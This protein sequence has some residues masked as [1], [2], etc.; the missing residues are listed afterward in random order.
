M[1]LFFLPFISRKCNSATVR[2]RRLVGPAPAQGPCTFWGEGGLHYPLLPH[3]AKVLLG[4]LLQQ[5]ARGLLLRGGQGLTVMTTIL[6][7]LSLRDGETPALVFLQ[8]VFGQPGAERER[9]SK[10]VWAAAKPRRR[11]RTA[12]GAAGGGLG[13]LTEGAVQLPDCT[14][15][16]AGPLP[17]RRRRQR[18]AAR[19]LRSL[20]PRSRAGS[21][22]RFRPPLARW[23]PRPQED[24]PFPAP[25]G[26]GGYALASLYAGSFGGNVHSSLLF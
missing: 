2:A 16:N 19:P 6:P 13:E 1:G 8:H 11:G 24:P 4:P 12:D 26:F 18:R 15:E 5:G 17:Q 22:G 3:G 21:R 20:S 7:P 23:W 25:S 10:G 9:G 14:A